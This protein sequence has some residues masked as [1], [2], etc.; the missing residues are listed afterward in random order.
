MKIYTKTGDKGETGLYGGKRVS[1]DTPRVEAYGE[2]DELNA[3]IGFVLSEKLD[4]QLRKILAPIQNDLFVVGAEL[5]TTSTDK[6]SKITKTRIAEL[7]KTM[8]SFD[9]ELK[10]LRK[11]ILPGG[12]TPAAALHVARTV[13]R[14]AERK[15][16]TLASKEQVRP[17][18]ITY[19]NRLSDL[20]FTLARVINSRAHTVETEW[21]P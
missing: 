9:T 4:F 16:V 3:Y 20:L 12:A 15:V 8:D 19:L 17:E 14:R 6:I 13:C 11:F 7:E 5:A 21:N 1:K 18:I 10:P 2:V